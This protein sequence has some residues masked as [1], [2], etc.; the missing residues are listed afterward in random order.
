MNTLLVCTLLA[1]NDTPPHNISLL[2]SCIT[3]FNFYCLTPPVLLTCLSN[4]MVSFL[5]G[6]NEVF[7][8]LLTPVDLT[9]NLTHIY[10]LI[11]ML[12]FILSS[13]LGK[14]MNLL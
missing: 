12:A 7:T 4:N 9:E 1:I 2:P 11:N 13:C 6:E 3:I 5:R 14:E 8:L 10:Q